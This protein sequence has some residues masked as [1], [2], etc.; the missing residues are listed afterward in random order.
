MVEPKL[1]LATTPCRPGV[2]TPITLLDSAAAM[3]VAATAPERTAGSNLPLDDIAVLSP[4]RSG[5]PCPCYR[6]QYEVAWL[7]RS[8]SVSMQATRPKTVVAKTESSLCFRF[9][10]LKSQKKIE[11]LIFACVPNFLWSPKFPSLLN[12]LFN[13]HISQNGAIFYFSFFY[14]N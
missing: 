1:H 9:R 8:Q 10:N 2:S 11:I 5:A 3:A 12:N 14:I 6:L 4:L 13:T 7:V